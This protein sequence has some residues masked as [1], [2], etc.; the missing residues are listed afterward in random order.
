M[1]ENVP[2]ELQRND[3]VHVGGAPVQQVSHILSSCLYVIIF[4]LNIYDI[5]GAVIR[6]IRYY[7]KADN[8]ISVSSHI[9]YSNVQSIVP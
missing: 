3:F 1:E 7:Y 4:M 8:S 5:I 6:C 2:K 9:L